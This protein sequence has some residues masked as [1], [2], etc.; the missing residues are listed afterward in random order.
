MKHEL[1]FQAH[2]I[3]AVGELADCWQARPEATTGNDIPA[4][5]V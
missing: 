3:V 1:E 4:Q 2:T 5:S